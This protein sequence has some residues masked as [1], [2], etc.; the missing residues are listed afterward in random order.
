MPFLSCFL[1][2]YEFKLKTML[3]SIFRVFLSTLNVFTGEICRN[4]VT[5]APDEV[6]QY[7]KKLK[8]LCLAA[9]APSTVRTHGYAS[10][11]WKK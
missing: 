6:G 3:I 10:Q 7:Q 11:R 9:R 1:N 2:H 5:K 8:R 4:M